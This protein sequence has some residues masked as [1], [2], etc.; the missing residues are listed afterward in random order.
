[1]V[2]IAGHDGANLGGGDGARVAEGRGTEAA[3]PSPTSRRTN[4]NRPNTA[5][6]TMAPLSSADLRRVVGG[7]FKVS[8]NGNKK[9]D[10]NLTKHKK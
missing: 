2:Q 9:D 7:N 8:G 3:L 5:D 1:L 10:A 4:M 6:S